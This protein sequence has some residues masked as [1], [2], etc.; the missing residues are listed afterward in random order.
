MSGPGGHVFHLGACACGQ[1]F[2][3]DPKRCLM[4]NY[5]CIVDNLRRS[6]GLRFS[7][8]TE[9]VWREADHVGVHNGGLI[10]EAINVGLMFVRESADPPGL[11]CYLNHELAD[12]LFGAMR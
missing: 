11:L 1:R 3:D 10:D 7:L 5:R 6:P 2:T 8:L 4:E 12:R 9:A